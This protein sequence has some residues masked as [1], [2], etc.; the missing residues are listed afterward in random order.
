MHRFLSKF[1]SFLLVIS[2]LSA[3]RSAVTP[4]SAAQ[5]ESPNPFASPSSM[6]TTEENIVPS[7]GDLIKTALENGEIDSTTALKYNLYGQFLDKRLPSKYQGSPNPGTDSHVVDELAAVFDTLSAEDQKALM[8]FLMPPVYKGSWA[9]LESSNAQTGDNSTLQEISY[10]PRPASVPTPAPKK[11]DCETINSE[12][13]LFKKAGSLPVRF[14]WSLSRP[15]DEAAVDN[16]IT[17]MESVIWKDITGLMGKPI[18]DE[19]TTCNGGS[20]DLDI[21]VTP[22]IASSAAPSLAPPGCKKTPGYILIKPTE[23]PSTLAHEFMH[24]IQWSFETKHGC[25]YSGEYAWLSEATATWAEDYIYPKANTERDFLEFFY[26]T[27]S[28]IAPSLNY[29]N[30]KH[31]YGAYLFFFYLTHKFD[32]NGI[33]RLV[34]DNTTSMKSLDAVD[35]AIPGGFKDVWGDFA[36]LNWIEQ[37]K[38]DYKTWDGLAIKPS[39]GSLKKEKLKPGVWESYVTVDH[40]AI[41]YEWYTFSEDSRLVT[42]MNGW[43]FDITDEAIN[44]Y[45]GVV[46]INDGT[47]QLK[48]TKK[49]KP[50]EGIKIQAYFKVAGEAKWQLE[51]WT[52]KPYVSFCRDAAKERLTDLVI[53]TSDSTQPTD[54][55]IGSIASMSDKIP[56]RIEVSSAGCYQYKGTAS[57]IFTA[58][59]ESGTLVDEQVVQDVVFER[60]DEHPNI[61]YPI[62]TMNVKGGQWSRTTTYNGKECIGSGAGKTDLAGSMTTGYTNHLYLLYGAVSGPSM[63]RYSGSADTGKSIDATVICPDQTGTG[64]FQSYPW[65]GVDWLSVVNKVVFKWTEDG[66]L[67]G[68]GD[69]IENASNGSMTF[70]WDLAP[71]KETAKAGDKPESAPATAS[72]GSSSSGGS[73]A[74]KIPS[75]PNVP[76][77]PNAANVTQVNDSLIAYTTDTLS[78]VSDFYKSEMV[79]LGWADV[80]TPPME[81]G[82]NSLLL[83]FMMNSSVAMIQLS[84][85]EQGTQIVISEYSQ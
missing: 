43:N 9:D 61:P 21:Y 5:T 76:N 62:L 57:M 71:Q 70:R 22:E 55:S 6:P 38:N 72:T 17:A 11:I 68:T 18:S 35:K 63:T 48:F 66:S 15:G 2:F 32:N 49:T 14:W 27:G 10:S 36:V 65:F 69:F 8:P 41:R 79:K 24:V 37:P 19:K 81:G 59:G 39:G 4:P 82:E 75:L 53:I 13:W 67:Q 33:V 47:K 46:P 80:S 56:P 84:G 60:T 74:T 23:P 12:L 58:A 40:L 26:D 34:W 45:M 83:M 54:A 42:Y 85:D 25:M 28:S 16:Y 77:Y 20:S 29:S 31:E 78:I 73:K 44:T 51:D 50:M 30:K 64:K 7:T 52:D 1:L 3:C